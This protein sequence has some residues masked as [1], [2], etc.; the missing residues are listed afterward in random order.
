MTSKKMGEKVN[1]NH[2]LILKEING[3]LSVLEEPIKDGS[4]IINEIAAAVENPNKSLLD[5][6]F[7]FLTIFIV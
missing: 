5:V 6:Q 4:L 7:L 1:E 2:I 3:K